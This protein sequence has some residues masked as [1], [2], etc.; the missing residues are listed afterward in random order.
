M[1]IQRIFAMTMAILMLS[2]TA[3]FASMYVRE[4][5][6]SDCARYLSQKK[7]AIFMKYGSGYRM[8]DPSST[9]SAE[10]D[11]DAKLPGDRTDLFTSNIACRNYLEEKGRYDNRVETR[12]EG[13]NAILF[14]K[15]VKSR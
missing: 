9:S 12:I 13:E 15:W 1:K 2:M 8:F 3:C 10:Y 6:P 4:I 5:S 14:T 11:F 7:F